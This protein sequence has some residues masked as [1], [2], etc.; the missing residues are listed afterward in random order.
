MDRL[1]YFVHPIYINVV[2]L[3]RNTSLYNATQFNSTTNYIL[4]N[5]NRNK[6]DLLKTDLLQ[7]CCTRLN[8]FELHVPN[9][10][11]YAAYAGSCEDKTIMSKKV[12]KLPVSQRAV[13]FV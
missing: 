1:F 10:L 3:H 2:G 9:T 11:E 7:D 6:S 8:S 12:K 5:Q 4:H 13:L